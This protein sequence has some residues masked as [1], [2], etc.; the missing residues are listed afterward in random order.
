MQERAEKVAPMDAVRTRYYLRVLVPDQAGVLARITAVLGEQCGISI[1]SI[2]RRMVA[3]AAP[4]RFLVH[5]YDWW[6]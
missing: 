4:R 2:I 3:P 6:E 1:A 5:L